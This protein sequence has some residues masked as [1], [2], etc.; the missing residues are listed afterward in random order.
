MPSR[1]KR[2]PVK[3]LAGRVAVVAGATRGA[4]RGIARGLAEAGAIM[5][6]TGQL[7]SSWDLA[8]EFRFTDAD[9][10]RPDWGTHKVDFSRHPDWLVALIRNGCEIQI[11]WLASIAGRTA[12][13]L[14]KLPKKKVA[15]RAKRA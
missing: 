13:F 8:R 12:F 7:F 11:D 5:A 10:R 15:R 4:G 1:A 6:R 14:K 3:P 2:S 9:G